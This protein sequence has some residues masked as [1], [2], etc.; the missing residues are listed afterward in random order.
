MINSQ[1]RKYLSRLP[2]KRKQTSLGTLVISIN[3][4]PIKRLKNPRVTISGTLMILFKLKKKN[5][6]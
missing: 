2:R 5:H 4:T 6:R 1:S 3:Q